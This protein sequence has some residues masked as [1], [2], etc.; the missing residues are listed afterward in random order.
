MIPAPGP[1]DWLAL[2]VPSAT[3]GF[4]CYITDANGRKIAA[5]WSMTEVKGMA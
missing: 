1:W 2:G 5:V 4:H 3:G